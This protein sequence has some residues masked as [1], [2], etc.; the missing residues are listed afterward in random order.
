MGRSVLG[1]VAAM[2]AATVSGDAGVEVGEFIHHR[3]SL[4]PAVCCSAEK[5]VHSPNG[6]KLTKCWRQSR[7]SADIHGDLSDCCSG[8]DGWW[9][10]AR[11]HNPLRTKVAPEQSL[12]GQPNAGQSTVVSRRQ[13]HL[14]Q[15]GENRRR[16]AMA[17]RQLISATPR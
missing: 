5:R 2:L 3:D 1:A 14:E 15:L 13:S 10:A 6:I 4:D 17:Q 9:T 12:Y 11:D 8:A 7:L 16:P